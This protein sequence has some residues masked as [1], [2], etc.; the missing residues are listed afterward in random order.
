MMFLFSRSSRTDK[1]SDALAS[2]EMARLD[3]LL[4]QRDFTPASEDAVASILQ[5]ARA[6]P[7]KEI[8]RPLYSPAFSIGDVLRRYVEPAPAFV[9]TCVLVLGLWLGQQHAEII[10]QPNGSMAGSVATVDMSNV[11]DMEGLL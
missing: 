10:T 9:F 6:H 8:T 7:R 11:M 3:A 1:S 4:M 2:E 5:A